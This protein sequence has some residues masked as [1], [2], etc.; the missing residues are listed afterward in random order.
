[1]N[2]VTLMKK[3]AAFRRQKKILILPPLRRQIAGNFENPY[4]LEHYN[5]R[6]IKLF[7][8]EY[9]RNYGVSPTASE[10]QEI[11]LFPA[12]E[13]MLWLHIYLSKL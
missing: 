12:N 8:N 7:C 5:N 11:S 4:D 10:I 3:T 9:V 6:D 2:I 1:M 13:N